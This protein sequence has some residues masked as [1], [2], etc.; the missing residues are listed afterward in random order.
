MPKII[1]DVV[2]GILLELRNHQRWLEFRKQNLVLIATLKFV[3]KQNKKNQKIHN[4]Q[5]KTKDTY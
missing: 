1:I 5:V 3:L 4:Q 2:F